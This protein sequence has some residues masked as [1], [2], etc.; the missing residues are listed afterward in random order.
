MKRWKQILSL[1]L[2]LSTLFAFAA[3]GSN[4]SESVKV[5]SEPI[6]DEGETAAAPAENDEPRI[7]RLGMDGEPMSLDPENLA[8]GNSLQ[9]VGWASYGTLWKITTEGEMLYLLA[10]SYE[11]RDDGL[12]IV[13]HLR[14]TGFNNGDP[15][16]AAD[17]LFSL[18]HSDEAMGDRTTA[19]DLENSY[20][21]DDKTLILKLKYTTPTLIDDIGVVCMISESWTEG[22]TNEEHI[23]V[24]P[25]FCGPYYI[26]SGWSSG[27]E[28]TLLKNEYYY[29]ADNLAYD[30]LVVSFMP[31]ETTRYLS[32]D[33]GE[34]DICYL[35]ESE[36][37]DKAA[38]AY[39]M[40]TAPV[41][42]ITGIVIDTENENSPYTNQNLRLAMMYAVDVPA[43]VDSICGDAYIS[44]TSVL[45]SSSWAYKDESYGYDPE[46]AKEYVNKY[47]EETG[48]A[49]PSVVLSVHEGNID[50]GIA[51][52]VQY[53]YSQVGITCEV[54]VLDFPSFFGAMLTNSMYC[55]LT[56][57]SGSKDPGGVLNSWNP[58]S[59]YTMFDYPEDLSQ[60]IREACFTVL[61]DDERLEKLYEM[62][63]SIKDFGKIL[64]IYE[65]TI[66]YAVADSSIDI[67]HSVQA[68]GYLI[69]DLI[70]V[71]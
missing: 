48:D 55:Y 50:E 25:L 2:A 23:Y 8:G 35:S 26:Q 63:D 54:Q 33:A 65:S 12:T 52:A 20:A 64:P 7:L 6:A 60:L 66:N 57:Y 42:S 41:Q 16:T 32:F 30:E 56:M 18:R 39:D 51:E 5:D 28:M 4:N 68:D 17:A 49:A 3:C 1:L 44:A 13:I 24:E 62:Q 47:I 58:D 53:Y 10:E 46:L 31:D 27:E 36:N 29:N 43:V 69:P 67:S 59:A 14:D 19:M 40:F 71:S 61:P 38:A 34:Y 9:F 37:I 21:E 11:E 70:T 45:P 22:Y 15:F